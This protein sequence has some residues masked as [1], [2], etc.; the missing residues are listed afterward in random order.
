M[1]D[2]Y[3]KVPQPIDFDLPQDHKRVSNGDE[4]PTA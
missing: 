3:S 1:D 4:K 2:Y